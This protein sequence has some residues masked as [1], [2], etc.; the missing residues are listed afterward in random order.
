MGYLL[1]FIVLFKCD[2]SEQSRSTFLLLVDYI[3]C[4]ISD[5]FGLKYCLPV[6]LAICWHLKDHPSGVKEK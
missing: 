2:A 3:S 5:K 4:I 6:S 1:H